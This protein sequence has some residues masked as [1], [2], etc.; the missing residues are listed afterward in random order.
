MSRGAILRAAAQ[1][2]HTIG[3]TVRSYEVMLTP[4]SNKDNQIIVELVEK[5]F[6]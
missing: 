5:L 3:L 2:I 4:I 6:C 1:F